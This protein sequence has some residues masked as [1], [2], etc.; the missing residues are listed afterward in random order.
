MATNP[1]YPQFPEDDP[2]KK[3]RP[4]DDHAKVEIIKKGKFPWPLVAI[5]VA[6]AILI[7][8]IVW[9]PTISQ[10]SP[11]PSA[12][13]VP[14]QPTAAQIQLT[15]LKMAPAPVGAALY[16][17]G[18]LHNQGTTAIT[19][20]QVKADFLGTNGQVLISETKP[21]E[22][23]TGDESAHVEN[24]SNAPIQPNQTRPFRIYFDNFPQS[25]NHQVPQLTITTVT[26]TT[27]S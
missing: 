20:A 15:N 5:L 22:Q 21:L 2:Q 13:Q 17:S 10:H 26:G 24:F 19:G 25:W 7:A 16:I 9:L 1:K 23:V 12:A 8:L 11:A 27:P 6:A 4:V 18:M 3:L 14:Q